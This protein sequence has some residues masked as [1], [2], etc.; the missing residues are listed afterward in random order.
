MREYSLLIG[1][2][3][4]DS[5]DSKY[6]YGDQ[7]EINRSIHNKTEEICSYCK[8]K[9]KVNI[10]LHY[11]TLNITKDDERFK[12]VQDFIM[13]KENFAHSAQKFDKTFSS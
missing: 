11:K 6:F 9:K 3:A 10:F 13:H 12:N 1:C 4:C 5:G 2:P 7:A 8:G